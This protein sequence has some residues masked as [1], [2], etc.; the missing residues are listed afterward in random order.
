VAIVRPD[1]FGAGVAPCSP[2]DATCLVDR[3]FSTGLK[4]ALLQ[5]ALA[6]VVYGL[7]RGRR[8]GRPVAE[9]QPVQ[10]AASE[11]VTATGHLLQQTRRPADAAAV[12]RHDARRR[13]GARVGVPADAAPEVVIE[14]VAA[15]TGRS[16]A[17]VAPALASAP[18]HTDADLVDVARRVG[19][20]RKEMLR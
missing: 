14:T 13:I 11:L 8:L 9:P 6:L 5:G 16:P 18:V 10:I 3:I 12:L 1:A 4:L 19:D 2:F 20:V 15:R 7:A 17:D